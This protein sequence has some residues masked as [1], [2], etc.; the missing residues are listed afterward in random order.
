MLS[1]AVAELELQLISE[2]RDDGGRSQGCGLGGLW[3][4]TGFRERSAEHDPSDLKPEA[5]GELRAV[6]LPPP[7][8]FPWKQTG[9]V[10]TFPLVTALTSWGARV[11]REPPCPEPRTKSTE[12]RV[13]ARLPWKMAAAVDKGRGRREE[14]ASRRRWVVPMHE[15]PR[16]RANSAKGRFRSDGSF[17]HVSLDYCVRAIVFSPSC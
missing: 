16:P 2:S 8:S 12:G 4:F 13:T 7:N 1:A 11:T 6:R 17:P 14:E 9:V 15:A 5:P 3:G 10:S